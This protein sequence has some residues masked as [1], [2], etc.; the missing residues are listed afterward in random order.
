MHS[1]DWRSALTRRRLS[2]VA[3]EHRT[4]SLHRQIV[5]SRSL[6]VSLH[7]QAVSPSD[8]MVSLH[9]QVIS[10]SGRAV[11]LHRQAVSP[12]SRTVSLRRQAVSRRSR[13]VSP[14]RQPA[15]TLPLR[16]RPDLLRLLRHRPHYTANGISAIFPSR[17]KL[18]AIA[19]V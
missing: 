17:A 13:T 16:P 12:R 2:Q 5:R 7:C 14:C 8:L 3:A 6:T 15:G 9:R 1:P 19:C 4:V 10:P 11:S 18:S